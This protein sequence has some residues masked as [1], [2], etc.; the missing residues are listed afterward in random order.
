MNFEYFIARN[1][2]KAGVKSFSRLIIR[3]A[4]V[5]V[6]LSMVVM[7]VATSLINGFQKGISSKIFGFWGHI[8]IVDT[9]VNRSF[10]A[11]PTKMNQDFYPHIDTIG[12]MLYRTKASIL[13]YELED[14][15]VDKMTKGGIRHIQ[16]YAQKPGIIKVKQEVKQTQTLDDQT[17]GRKKKKKTT[18]QLEGIIIKGIG[19][20]FDWENMSDYLVKGR[21]IELY[22]DKESKDI[23]VSEETARR[24]RL[25]IGSKLRI[26]FVEKVNMLERSFKVCGI[27]KTGMEEFD[28]KFALADIKVLQN[29]Y[30]WEADEVGG[31][32]VFLDDLDDL[33]VI[34]DY[35]YF[36]VLP[37]NM[38]AQT[39]RDKFPSIFDWL[40][41]QD[42]NKI[43]ILLLMVVVSIIN[44]ITALMILILERTNMIGTLKAMGSTDWSIRKIFL[45]HALYII[46]L[47]LMFG[48]IIGLALCYIQQRF[49]IITLSEKDYYLS[50]A[51]IEINLWTI[52]LLNIGTMLIT[53]LF[54]II[55]SYLVTRIN[56]VEA[57]RFK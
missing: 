19:A 42:I 33:D 31:F 28:R 26:H 40:D 38:F 30:N 57:I 5:A 36:E 52:L 1:V 49:E 22:D 11:V 12:S 13:G 55:P 43:V 34:R 53:L 27:Y 2:A 17:T 18:N 21:P 35:L 14:K 23:I 50:V 29:I 47:G 3:I 56:P 6:A 46:G 20:D 37:N 32:E 51:P 45:Y 15:M 7:I 41:L 25:D 54:L 10:E 16:V 8:D 39:I 4:M 48:N 9:N 24:L 44:M